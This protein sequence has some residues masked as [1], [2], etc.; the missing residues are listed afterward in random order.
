MGEKESATHLVPINRATHERWDGKGYPD[1]LSG[2][3]IP[4][5]SRIV[6]ACDAW[7]AMISE[8]PY[9]KA[10]SSEAMI[11]ELEKNAGQQFDPGVV[12]ALRE[13]LKT[14]RLQQPSRGTETIETGR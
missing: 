2:E 10:L 8:R 4:L 1:G 3:Q 6:F 13:V 14:H 12:Q 5:A 11:E 7:H 9:R